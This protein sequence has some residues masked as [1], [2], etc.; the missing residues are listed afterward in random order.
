[1]AE[2]RRPQNV[3]T[4]RRHWSVIHNCSDFP[5][6]SLYTD[7]ITLRKDGKWTVWHTSDSRWWTVS[8]ERRNRAWNSLSSYFVSGSTHSFTSRRL[9]M[10][11]NFKI[12][13]KYLVIICT[14]RHFVIFVKAK[15]SA[16]SLR[17]KLELKAERV[18]L[19]WCNEQSP[20]T[21]SRRPFDRVQHWTSMV[22]SALSGCPSA[23]WYGVHA[24]RLSVYYMCSTYSRCLDAT[25]LY[26]MWQSRWNSWITW[27]GDDSGPLERM[28]TSNVWRLT[29]K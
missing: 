2:R 7:R 8:F 25:V 23:A 26:V 29:K 4:E 6:F 10:F 11:V 18:C 15:F 3:V 22:Q 16:W 12:S 13:K 9:L 20:R 17:F 27:T 5:W 1:V 19:K 28:L 21:G 24:N 14:N